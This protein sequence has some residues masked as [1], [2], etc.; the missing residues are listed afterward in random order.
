M[1]SHYEIPL[2]RKQVDEIL[3]G[4]NQKQRDFITNYVVQNKKSIWLETL[5]K[6]KGIFI[7][8]GMPQSEIEK[9]LDDWILKDIKDCG[10]GHRD[11]RCECGKSLRFQYIVFHTKQNKTYELGS[12]CF[13]DYTK[14]SS[15]IISDIKKGFYHIDLERDEILIKWIRGIKDDLSFYFKLNLSLPS[16]IIIQN[17]IGLPLTDRQ[18]NLIHKLLEQYEEHKRNKEKNNRQQQLKNEQKHWESYEINKKLVNKRS[19]EVSEVPHVEYSKN[20][21]EGKS[22]LLQS[23]SKQKSEVDYNYIMS[24]YL[25][26]LKKIREKEDILPEGLNKCWIDTQNLLRSLKKDGKFN[27]NKFRISLL[28]ICA[29]LRIKNNIIDIT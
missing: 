25:D 23:S 26:I 17:S 21:V 14:L 29:F 28:K 18:K 19:L 9:M 7:S 22:R 27:Y 24:T 1:V 16:E 12:T 15:D 20:Y 5:A 3:G 13:K 2:T 11:Y 6:R 10:P 4:M 8:E